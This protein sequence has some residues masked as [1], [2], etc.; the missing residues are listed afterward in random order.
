VDFTFIRQEVRG[1]YGVRGNPSLDPALVL[2]L[3]FLLFYENVSSG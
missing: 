1:L 3:L 2:K